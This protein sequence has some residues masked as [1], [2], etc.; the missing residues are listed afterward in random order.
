MAGSRFGSPPAACAGCSSLVV[1][2]RAVRLAEMAAEGRPLVVPGQEDE[3]ERREPAGTVE[4]AA[5]LALP[6][7]RCPLHSQG[8]AAATAGQKK[9]RRRRSGR[10]HLVSRSREEGPSGGSGG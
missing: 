8:A 9:R 10:R 5:R 7:T 1:W 2:C 6:L 3:G 4:L